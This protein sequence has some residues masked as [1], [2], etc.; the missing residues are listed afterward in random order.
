[1]L[2]WIQSKL[3]IFCSER[4]SLVNNNKLTK[5]LRKGAAMILKRADI[6]KFHQNSSYLL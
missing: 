2:D 4:F 3:K 6:K 5:N 1:M